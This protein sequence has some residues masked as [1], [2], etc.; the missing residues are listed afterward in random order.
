MAAA[1]RCRRGSRWPPTKEESFRRLWRPTQQRPA[2]RRCRELGAWWCS[3]TPGSSPRARGRLLA[4][5]VDA[6]PWRW[7]TSRPRTACWPAI[8][9]AYSSQEMGNAITKRKI[10]HYFIPFRVVVRTEE[11]ITYV[12]SGSG[13]EAVVRAEFEARVDGRQLHRQELSRNQE[14]SCSDSEATARTLFYKR[15]L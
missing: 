2:A 10:I 4:V 15:V 8:R 3:R 13:D 14:P 11:E 5:A 6:V 1:P 7:R 9:Y 12:V